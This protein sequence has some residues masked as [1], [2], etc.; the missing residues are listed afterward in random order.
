MSHFSITVQNQNFLFDNYV[1]DNSHKIHSQIVGLRYFNV[2]GPYEQHK[3]VMS[4]VVFHFYNQLKNQGM[5]KLSEEVMDIMTVNRERDFVYVDDDKNKSLWF[6]NNNISGIYNVATGKSRS[7]NDVNAVINHFKSG[8]I[9]YID[10][11]DEDEKQYQA[12]T[13]A[14]YD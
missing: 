4:G 1:R 11:P 7:F 5:L 9:E 6:M 3:E 14:R 12:F 10:F 2:Y 8:H 13:R